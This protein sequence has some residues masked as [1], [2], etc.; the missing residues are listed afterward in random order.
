MRQNDMAIIKIGVIL[1][2]LCLFAAGTVAQERSPL[3]IAQALDQESRRLEDAQE[4]VRIPA[5][6]KLLARIREQ[7]PQFEITLA[8]NVAIDHAGGSDRGALQDIADTLAKALRD[9]PKNPITSSAYR[10]LA[11]L[12]RY[13]QVSVSLDDPQYLA[14]VRDLERE[15]EQ[16]RNADFNLTDLDGKKWTL[17]ALRGK[18]VL[19]NFWASWCSPCRKEIPTLKLAY[20]HF[21]GQGFIVLAISQE[22][23]ATLKK[24]VVENGLQFPVLLDARAKVE[25][26][27]Y[28]AIGVPVSFIYDRSGTIV[29]QAR[30]F[31]TM[32]RLVEK[33]RIAGLR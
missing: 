20:D 7:P 6:R 16:R 32:E 25:E 10:T 3:E 28:H 22:D 2:V 13:D 26:N 1:C 33:L 19:V 14:A 29:A 8:W 11:E 17:Q 4:D 23:P 18:V 9:A 12:A 30:S 5:V 24:F 21:K 15:D 27:A 31:P